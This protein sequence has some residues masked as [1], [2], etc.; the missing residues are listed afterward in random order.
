MRLIANE[1]SPGAIPGYR[2]QSRRVV[3]LGLITA[4]F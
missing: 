3:K 1:E 2:I 4:A